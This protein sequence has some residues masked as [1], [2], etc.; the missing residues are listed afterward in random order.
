MRGT[1]ERA[2]CF[3]PSCGGV[4]NQRPEAS[5]GRARQR[6]SAYGNDMLAPVECDTHDPMGGWS[7]R[8]PEGSGTLA[9]CPK[10][11]LAN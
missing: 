2:V 11:N 5:T 6:V 8:M 9:A 1:R 10:K 4:S 3:L 7:A